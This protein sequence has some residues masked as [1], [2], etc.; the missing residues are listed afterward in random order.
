MNIDGLGPA[1]VK[2]LLDSKTISSV[3][4][5]YTITYEDLVKVD[6][7]AD[8]SAKN[9]LKAIENSKSN[10]LDRLVLHWGYAI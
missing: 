6:R 7:F 2:A 4:D 1:N 8:K 5:L 3:A 9:L 10:H